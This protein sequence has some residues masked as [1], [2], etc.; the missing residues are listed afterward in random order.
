MW[1]NSLSPL[2]H[3]ESLDSSAFSGHHWRVRFGE[4]FDWDTSRSY[5]SV[6]DCHSKPLKS[7]KHL[8]CSIG[9]S[10][11]VCRSA[12]QTIFLVHIGNYY[13][14]FQIYVWNS[15]DHTGYA[16]RMQLNFLET[17]TFAS[18]W[19][20]VHVAHFWILIWPVLH[21]RSLLLSMSS[22]ET[23]PTVRLPQFLK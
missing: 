6:L 7:N 19:S 21:I 20:K 17:Y 1:I 12:S 14:V 2:I 9:R 18:L 13:H 4:F 15:D 8:S 16:C 5:T 3:L 10:S 11:T 23:L 22:F